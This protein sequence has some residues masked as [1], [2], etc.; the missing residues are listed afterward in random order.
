MNLKDTYLLALDTADL[1]ESS[2]HRTRFKELLDCFSGYSFFSKG[3]CKCMYLS[4][5]DDEHF[6]IILEILNAM[7]LGKDPN[8]NEMRINGDILAEEQT[9]GEYYVYLLSN[10]FL[11]NK[12]FHLSENAKIEPENSYIIEQA[13]KASEIIDSIH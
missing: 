4:A 11:D 1:F 12:S 6:V 8:T 9:N 7:A 5:W 3:L 10:A 2:A 13:L